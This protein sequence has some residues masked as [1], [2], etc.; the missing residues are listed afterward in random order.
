MPLD[1]R[2]LKTYFHT[3][4]GVVPAG[5][6]MTYNMCPGETVALMGESRCGK[7]LSALS[8]MRLVS[9]PAGRI[10]G[11]QILFQGRDLLSPAGRATQSD[12]APH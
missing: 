11:G 4:A 7:S 10:V 2:D 8:V 5:D 3:A 6:G 12:L 9:A 1:D